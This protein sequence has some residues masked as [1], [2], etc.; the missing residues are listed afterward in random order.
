MT[1]MLTKL[2]IAG[3]IALMPIGLQAQV[4]TPQ[5]TGQANQG[6]GNSGGQNTHTVHTQEQQGGSDPVMGNVIPGFDPGSETMFFEGQLWDV[7]NNRLMNARF[8]KY[9]NTPPATDG[10]DEEYRRAIRAVLDALSPHNKRSGGRPDLNKAVSFLEVAADSKYEKQDGRLSESLANAIYRVWLARRSVQNL[11]LANDRLRRERKDQA[12]NFEIAVEG[13]SLARPS[14]GD[15]DADNGSGKA[16]SEVSQAGIYATRYAEIQ[17]K[18]TANDTKAAI[19]ETA[20]RLEFQ[21]L[22]AQFLGQRRFEHVVMAARL[23][24]EFYSDGGGTIELKDGSDA[25]KMFKESV[26]FDP[27]VTGMETMANELIQDTKNGVEA[28]NYLIEKGERASASKRLMEAFFVGEHL[29]PVQTVSLDKKQ[30]ILKFVQGYNQLLS[31]LSVKDYALAEEKVL[32]LRSF[33]SD[34]DHSKPLQAVKIR[35]SGQRW[36]RHGSGQRGNERESGGI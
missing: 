27:T 2:G 7:N 31:A 4:F 28:F 16:L 32:E 23:Y 1:R 5:S 33:A 13:S 35:K 3:L 17:A 36:S 18:I 11:E 14:E 6:G 10:A 19:S 29:P 8:E 26:G 25:E 15:E 21:A 30:S 9:L 20:S 22:L 24:T 12:R 34:F